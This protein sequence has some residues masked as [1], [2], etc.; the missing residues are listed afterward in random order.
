MGRKEAVGGVGGGVAATEEYEPQAENGD[1]ERARVFMERIEEVIAKVR[2]L[3]AEYGAPPD[4]VEA[5]YRLMIDRFIALE[6]EEFE[7]LHAPPA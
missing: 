6:A 2:G 3:A 7:R 5:V 4:L 1:T